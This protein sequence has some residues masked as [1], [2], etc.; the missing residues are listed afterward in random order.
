MTKFLEEYRFNETLQYIWLEISNADKK[1][2][3]EKPW[4]LEGEKAKAVLE[5]LV[6]QIQAI[7]YNLQPFMP[8][9][10]EKILKQFSGE[11]KSSSA[12]FP[13]I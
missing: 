1:V 3:E 7:A 12:L 13:R 9:T 5:V 6:K 2:N 10:A 11:V 4:E 8:E